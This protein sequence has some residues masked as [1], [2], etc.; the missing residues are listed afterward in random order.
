MIV[1]G[2]G[3]APEVKV[4][5]STRFNELEKEIYQVY[6]LAILTL[7]TGLLSHP[8]I[9]SVWTVLRIVQLYCGYLVRT[10]CSVS[11]RGPRRSACARHTQHK[12]CAVAVNTHGLLRFAGLKGLAFSLR[13]YHCHTLKTPRERLPRLSLS[14]R[15]AAKN[16][17]P[18]CEAKKISRKPIRLF[19]HSPAL[20]E[21][22][23]T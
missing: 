23:A 10:V 16:K 8:I 4:E 13:C 12:R 3:I 6:I 17:T 22:N 1:C 9:T 20:P 21:K 18:H 2:V 7:P 5:E 14:S 15:A 11:H 19:V